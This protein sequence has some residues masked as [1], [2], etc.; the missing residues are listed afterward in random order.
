MA[1]ENTASSVSCHSSILFSA[2]IRNA[3]SPSPTIRFE[4]LMGLFYH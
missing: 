4:F 3:Q 2:Y 1:G